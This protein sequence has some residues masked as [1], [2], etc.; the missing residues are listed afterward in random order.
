MDFVVPR[1]REAVDAYECKWSS[2][3]PD[4]G[5]LRAFRA[6]YPQGKNYLVV[7]QRSA[8]PMLRLDGLVL[9]VVSP[10]PDDLLPVVLQR[11]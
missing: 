6:A 7:P 3:Q 8:A 9:H 11:G 4:L 10:A 5:N 2:L 1:G